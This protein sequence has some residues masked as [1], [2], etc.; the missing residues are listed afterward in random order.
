MQNGSSDG[1]GAVLAGNYKRGSFQAG[2]ILPDAP[3]G[4][5]ATTVLRGK[6]RVSPTKNGDPMI[7]FQVRLDTAAEEDNESSQ[8]TQL[9]LRVIITDDRDGKTPAFAKR[10]TKMLLRSLA[11]QCGFDLDILPSE[12]GDTEEAVKAAFAPFIAAVEGSNLQVWTTHRERKGEAGV[13]DVDVN[14]TKPGSAFGPGTGLGS[15]AT[16]DEE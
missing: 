15:R 10:R 2:T 4:E 1:S 11:D 14:L 8:G 5:W 12:W 16:D 13:I 7:T 3:V 6:T 9:P